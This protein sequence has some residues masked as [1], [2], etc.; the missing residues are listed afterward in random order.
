VGNVHLRDDLLRLLHLFRRT[1]LLRVA[2]HS[3]AMLDQQPAQF[4]DRVK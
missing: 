1:G 2:A 3:F 4:L